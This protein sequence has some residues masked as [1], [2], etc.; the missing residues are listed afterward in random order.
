MGLTDVK[1]PS[2]PGL[3]EIT[4]NTDQHHDASSPCMS[5]NLQP[6]SFMKTPASTPVAVAL[7]AALDD[8]QLLAHCCEGGCCCVQ[9]LAVMSC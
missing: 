8:S 5:V 3:T 7:P 6:C 2:S 1:T 9:L 4:D